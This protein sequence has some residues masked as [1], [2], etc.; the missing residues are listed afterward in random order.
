MRRFALS[1]IE[2]KISSKNARIPE[3]VF[4]GGRIFA[5]G[6][7]RGLFSADG[8]IGKDGIISF[9]TVQ[10]NLLMMYNCYCYL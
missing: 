10:K 2:L 6:F 9:S 5:Q 7:L 8:S 1:S 3:I 4:R